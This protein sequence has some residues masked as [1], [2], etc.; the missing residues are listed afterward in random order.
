MGSGSICGIEKGELQAKDLDLAK[1]N[2]LRHIGL[3]AYRAGFIQQ[4]VEWQP[5]AL[6]QIES[7]E[8]LRVLWYGEKIHLQLA[9]EVP[10]VGVDTFEDLE[11]VR[12]ILA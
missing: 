11:K 12:Q 9:K 3:Y 7:L 5:T 2:Y 1:T 10:A 6:E 8:Q 4:Y